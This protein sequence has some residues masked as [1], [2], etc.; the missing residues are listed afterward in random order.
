MIGVDDPEISQA[1]HEDMTVLHD[2]TTVAGKKHI[3]CTDGK[4]GSTPRC[5]LVV[6]N[7]NVFC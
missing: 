1:C 6:L 2:A 7:E 5:A 4:Q 3:I